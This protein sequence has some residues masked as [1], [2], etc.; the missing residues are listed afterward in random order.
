VSHTGLELVAAALALNLPFG[1]YRAT[2]RRLSPKWFL[3]IHLPIPFIF[4]LRVGAHYGYAFIPWLVLGALA[5]QIAGARLWAWHRQRR[6]P[7]PVAVSSQPPE[8]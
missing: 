4:V 8:L 3:A 2:T 1:A 7:A 5:G 6:A